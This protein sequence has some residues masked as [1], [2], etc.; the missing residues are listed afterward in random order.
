MI[1]RLIIY[2]KSIITA[3]VILAIYNIFSHAGFLNSPRL[4]SQ[5]LFLKIKYKI[6]DKPASIDNIVIV[7]INDSAYRGRWPWDRDIFADLVYKLAKYN[8]AIIGFDL[9]FIEESTESRSSDYLFSSALKDF[10]RVVLA[11]YID[12]EGKY[13]VPLLEFKDSA[14]AYGFTNKVEDNDH[15][16]RETQLLTLQSLTGEILDYSFDLKISC[17]FLGK[18]LGSINYANKELKYGKHKLKLENLCSTLINYCAK[19]EDFK[20]I[21][22]EDILENKSNLDVICGKIVL[23]GVTDE[24]FHDVSLTPFGKMPGVA[25]IANIITMLNSGNYLYR[26]PFIIELL[27]LLFIGVIAGILASRE[28]LYRGLFQVLSIFVISVLFNVFLISNNITTDFFAAPFIVF[29]VYIVVTAEEY[30]R[31]LMESF[32]VKKAVTIDSLTGLPV[33]RYFLLKLEKELENMIKVQNISLV[34]LSIDNIGNVLNEL[35]PDKL[36]MVV[37]RAAESIV[38]SSRKTR[39]MDFIARYGQTEFCAVLHMTDKKGALIYAERIRKIVSTQ[40]DIPGLNISAGISNINDV[41]NTSAKIFTKCAESALLRAKQ[42]GAGTICIYDPKTD[43]VDFE[44]SRNELEFSEVDFSYVAKEFEEKNKELAIMLNKLLIANEDVIKSERLSAVGKVA[45]TIHHDLSKPII[46]IKSSLKM[47]KSDIDRVDIADLLS[48]KKLLSSAI[49]ETER[50]SKL[51]D[52]LKDLYRPVKKEIANVNVNLLL[53]EMMGLSA[54][55]MIK[56]KIKLTKNLDNSLPQV[57]ANVHE[58]KQVFLNL[59][60]NAIEAMQNGGELF[61]ETKVATD[62][63]GMVLAAIKDTGCGIPPENMD[64]IFKAF[65]TTKKQQQGAG[66]G[67]YASYEIVK[68]YGGKIA[69]LSEPGEGTAFNVYL[70]VV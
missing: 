39:G 34:I 25:I 50:L 48:A 54:A 49:E 14:L 69:V 52:S 68:K 36:D 1:R 46:N 63:E 11:S 6:K 35:G 29:A 28:Y 24:V 70:P 13:L 47:I 31:L 18:S 16:I 5:D 2:K 9:G 55:Q 12:K 64:K 15:V 37:K 58:L 32:I 8:P 60:I 66:L 38:K 7:P 44:K 51:S 45:A 42:E 59:I 21:P 61:V 33:R 56:N 27:F 62:M 4:K 3:L 40:E 26:L 57:K 67:L 30:A 65:F 19:Y 43:V 17:L 23:I 20:I 41:K 10:G 53:E 22:I